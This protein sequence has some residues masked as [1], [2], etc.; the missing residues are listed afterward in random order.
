MP[1]VDT[2]G[3]AVES[4]AHRNAAGVLTPLIQAEQYVGE[5]FSIGYDTADVQIHDF[6]RQSAGG[7]P[8]LCFL[9]ATRVPPD[10]ELVD[11]DAEDSSLILLRVLDSAPL[12]DKVET[13]RVRV[14]TAQRVTGETDRHWDDPT[15][16]DASTAQVLSYAGL[17]CRV[18]GTFYLHR[19]NEDI[20]LRFGSDL[21]N[22]YPNRGLKV[23]KPT[24]DA[25]QRIVN[26]KVE[27]SGTAEVNVEVGTVRYASTVRRFQGVAGVPVSIAP[28]DLVG[29]RTALFGMTRTGKSN[30]VKTLVQSTVNLFNKL[31][32]EQR[33]GQIIFDINGEY[34]NPNR[35]DEGTA[36]SE[37]FEQITTRFSLLEKDGFQVMKL[38][39]YDALEDGFGL[40]Q[41]F[42]ATDSADYVRSF[43]AIDLTEPDP[44]DVSAHTRW[45]R[46]AAAYKACLFNAGFPIGTR[47]IRFEGQQDLNALSRIDPSRGISGE[48]AVAW[49]SAVWENY[50]TEPYL[51]NY[52][53]RKQGREWANED[54][55]AVLVMLT[56]R[57]SPGA[58]SA[59]LSGYRKLRPF[60]EYHSASAV[61]SF[62][63]DIVM[64]LRN[65]DIVVVDLSQGDPNI[66]RTYTER[67]CRNIFA[68]AMN[69][70]IRN[71]EPNFI[72]LYFEEAHNIFPRRDDTDLSIVY[73]RIAKEGAKLRLGLI[74]STQEVSSISSNILKNTQN[75]FIGHLNNTD[76]TRE[77]VKYYDF[78]D[79]ERSIRRAQDRGFLRVKTLANPFVIPVQ[80]HRFSASS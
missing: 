39:F 9:L 55:K 75:W 32:D 45:G 6:H 72:Q 23:Y 67:I 27:D 41:A 18:L 13:E 43:N 15:V 26:Y 54:L 30:T 16:M 38:N 17:R 56:R 4:E 29:Q 25:L 47:T 52:P 80:I 42:L 44:S 36:I 64:R 70:F 37:V 68:D 31:S 11:P 59:S 73:N 79:F 69:C 35:Q 74:Y 10:A 65:G 22:Y 77:L 33:A 51:T 8:S 58:G 61:A 28:A 60:S 21:S 3:Q 57:R 24:A 7:I 53:N 49:F 1:I 50:Q 46:L 76:E 71:E 34:A 66:Q 40:I 12:P 19:D 2:L 62:E 14:E 5:V 48:D 63:R 20:A 78:A